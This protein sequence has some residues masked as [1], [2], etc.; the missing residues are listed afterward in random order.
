MGTKNRLIAVAAASAAFAGLPSL[1]SAAPTGAKDLSAGLVTAY[2]TVYDRVV[3]VGGEPGRNIAED[4]VREGGEARSA[5]RSEVVESLTTLR[6]MHVDLK[7]D[8]AQAQASLQAPTT[9]SPA[10]A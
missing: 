9:G 10:P 4:G 5:T 8:S 3:K 6:R 7:P 1:A 2:D